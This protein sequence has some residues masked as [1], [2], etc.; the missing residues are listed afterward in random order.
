MSALQAVLFDLDG[1]LID[2]SH[3]GRR[4]NRRSRTATVADGVNMTLNARSANHC[5]TP[6]CNCSAGECRDPLK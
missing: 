6:R 4:K 2:S 1:T 3:D 5:G